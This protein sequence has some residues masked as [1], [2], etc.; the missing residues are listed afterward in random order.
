[1]WGGYDPQNPQATTDSRY[2]VD[3]NWSGDRT[4]EIVATLEREVMPDFSVGADFT[5]RRYDNFWVNRRY[6]DYAGG[7]LLER[8]DYVE[9]PHKVPTSYTVPDGT[10][11]DV[12][13]AAGRPFYVWKEGINDVYE[14]YATTTPSDYYDQYLGINLRF[15]KRLS[16]RWMLSG[17]FTYQSQKNY[18]GETWP[19]DPTNQ[20]AEDGQTYAYTLGA[21]S[22]KVG[23]PVFSRWMLKAQ[24]L[25]Q[26]PYGLNIS[27]VSDMREGHIVPTEISLQ[28]YT[29]PN[30]ASTGATMYTKVFGEERLPL[31]WNVNMRLEKVLKLGDTGRVY[32]MVDAFN[33]F[34]QNILNRKLSINPGTIYLHN[35]PPTFSKNARSGEPNEVLNPRIFRFGVRF[36][37]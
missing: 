13:D 4:Y 6:A 12:G 28:D 9:A 18:W 15:T 26:L 21:V 29:S 7:R 34:N 35:D 3:P 37:F 24:G 27:F 19:L 17:S 30:S 23:M 1:M 5:W 25:Y 32:L 2:T 22:G 8:T 11:V 14:L 16:N 10:V 31:F 33:V 20:W 36:Q